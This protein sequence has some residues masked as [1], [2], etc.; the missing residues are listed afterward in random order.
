MVLL[1]YIA[2]ACQII[3]KSQI[4]GINRF[5][6]TFSLP[7]LLFKSIA[8]LDFSQVNWLFL[9]S[10]F[11][12]KATI[13]FGALL[14]TLITMRPT[15]IGLAAVFAIYVSQSNDFALGYP[16]VSAIY[17]QTHPDY[18]HY[19]Y[20]I[21]PISL[22]ILNPIAFLLM[23]ANEVIFKRNQAQLALDNNINNRAYTSDSENERLID[24]DNEQEL[25][26]DENNNNVNSL[27]KRK[28]KLKSVNEIA[29]NNN[30]IPLSNNLMTTSISSNNFR[31]LLSKSSNQNHLSEIGEEKEIKLSKIKLIKT[32]LWSTIS[33]PIVFMTV[34]GL[35]ANF[36]LKQKI[37][38]Y[39]DPILT[40]LSNSFSALALF[41][42]GFSMVGKIKNLSFKKIVIILILVL[43]KSLIFPLITREIVLHL[44]NTQKMVPIN[45]VN[46]DTES[47][48]SFA[49]LYGTFPAAPSIFFYISR[50]KSI[51]DDLI[52]SALVFGTLASAPLMMISGKMISLK[53]SNSSVSN[54]EDIECKTAYGF[55]ILNWFCC[56]W[57]LYVFLASG[58][59]WRRSHRF[60]TLL[61]LSQ[62]A[63][64]AVHIIWSSLTVNVENLAPGYGYAHVA[65]G[66]L[67][68]F[69]TRFWVLAI[70]LNLITMCCSQRYGHFRTN[71]FILK[72]GMFRFVYYFIGIG[73]PILITILCMVVGGIPEKQ[74]MMI[75]IGKPQI[76]ISNIL[77][78]L[79]IVVIFYLLIVFARTK[80]D[81]DS[82]ISF[83][84]TYNSNNKRVHYSSVATNGNG[85]LIENKIESEDNEEGDTNQRVSVNSSLADHSIEVDEENNDTSISTQDTVFKSK[86][87]LIFNKI[88]SIN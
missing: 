25:L 20:L 21:A 22:C 11:L 77:L 56:I 53:Y 67:T 15:N 35:A 6:S 13:F 18:L 47:L 70:L 8:V 86:L 33:N 55:S 26:D 39:I 7:A 40:A 52:S 84:R 34:I 88:I 4:M 82:L 36:I 29:N 23:E 9:T 27:I 19:I 50:Y 41:Y 3:S 43:S 28:N 12:S 49:F 14:I 63:N 38:F 60:T 61:I 51:G 10:I 46:N 81:Q 76:I 17:S 58:R 30:N 1:G 54:F 16:I 59:F 5:V 87:F 66:L 2:A 68:A 69:L 31:D 74:K 71:A 24:S 73:F 65:I 79:L 78:F 42:L 64:S 72:L 83:I 32:T 85:S 48:S 75:S 37:P 62:M 57:V 45:G 80:T 44:D